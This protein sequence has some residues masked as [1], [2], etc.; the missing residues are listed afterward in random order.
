MSKR[1]LLSFVA[2]A[3][4]LALPARAS[5]L[6]KIS[7]AGDRIA[8]WLGVDSVLGVRLTAAPAAEAG[9]QE[10]PAAVAAAPAPAMIAAA[11]VTVRVTKADLIALKTPTILPVEAAALPEPSVEK[12]FKKFYCVEYAR[13]VSGLS[14][15][16][17][18][19]YWWE[20]ARNLY[21]RASQP[22]E[23]AVMVFAGSKRLARG[24]VAVVSQIV[25]AREIRVEQA[26]WM[27][28][29]EID[30]STPVL[31]VSTANDWSKV[32]VWDVPSHQFG[33]RVYAISGFI[34]KGLTK[35]ASAD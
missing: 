5:G 11:P 26:N 35:Q 15:F 7:V 19:K 34:L 2:S 10:A 13:L 25:S 20:R 6:D 30:H 28:K 18:A 21:A 33:S 8:S 1:L 14:V 9:A 16:G 12:G 17:D 3:C 31:D 22:V 32:R 24:H 23:D 4:L 27:N 29:G